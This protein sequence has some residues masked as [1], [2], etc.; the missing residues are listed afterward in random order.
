M[1]SHLVPK[2]PVPKKQS[3]S[4]TDA[5]QATVFPTAFQAFADEL[6]VPAKILWPS[7]VG[8][9]A[10]T[11]LKLLVKSVAKLDIFVPTVLTRQPLNLRT[12][13]KMFLLL[14]ESFLWPKMVA[15]G[16]GATNAV[17]ESEGRWSTTHGTEMHS[18]RE[19][20]NCYLYCCCKPSLS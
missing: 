7:L 11:S 18:Q 5:F 4:L 19:S 1:A 15:S 2:L 20:Q 10:R 8:L 6:K 13:G 14:M 12:L 3:D 9:L 16:I 17:E